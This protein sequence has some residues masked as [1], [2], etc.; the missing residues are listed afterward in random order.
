MEEIFSSLES[1]ENLKI[2]TFE[3]VGLSQEGK[4]NLQILHTVGSF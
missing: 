3:K 4:S 2:W 1:S